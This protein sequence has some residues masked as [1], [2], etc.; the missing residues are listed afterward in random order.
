MFRS[1]YE[2]NLINRFAAKYLKSE[3]Q[4]SCSKMSHEELDFSSTNEQ[5]M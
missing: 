5:S 3:L 4:I 2:K 1:N